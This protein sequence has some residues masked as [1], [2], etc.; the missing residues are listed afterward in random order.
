MIDPIQVH[1]TR[2]PER[3]S[4]IGSRAVPSTD[5]ASVLRQ[6]L[7][8]PKDV[9]FSA[10]AT[11]R[12]AVRN[13]SLPPSAHQAIARAVDAAAAKGGRESLLLMNDLALVVSVPNRTV[14]TVLDA[15]TGGDAV[16]TNIDSAVIVSAGGERPHEAQPVGPAP[17]PGSP[18][19]AERLTRHSE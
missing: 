13:I 4:P 2:E 16:F 6:R 10:H 8:A 14:I 17:L 15:H 3:P 7:D 9:A 1:P 18:R 12:L 5:F 19:V 11:Q